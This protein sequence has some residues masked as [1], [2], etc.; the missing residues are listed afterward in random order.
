M[1]NN[2][3]K[4]A[5]TPLFHKIHVNQNLSSPNLEWKEAEGAQAL[6]CSSWG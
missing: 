3:Q 4:P 5:S 1:Q 6:V 2:K